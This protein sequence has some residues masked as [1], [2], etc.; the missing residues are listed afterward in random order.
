[1][2]LKIRLETEVDGHYLEV[3]EK[4]DL[5][6]FEALKPTFGKMKVEEFTGSK[7]GD[8]VRLAFLSPVKTEWVSDIVED[9]AD[10]KEA[11]FIDEGRILPFP[12]SFWR[13]KHIVQKVS[14]GR[15]RIIDDMSFMGINIFFTLFLYPAIYIV[16]Y[17]RKNIYRKYFGN[18]KLN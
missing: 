15:S 3:I 1:M 16:F 13:H 14:E 18:S 6:L 11:Y 8:I 17:P 12:L 2:K 9:G 10:D 5:K 7:K 4:F